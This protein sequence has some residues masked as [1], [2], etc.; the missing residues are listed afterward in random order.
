MG[1]YNAARICLNGHVISRRVKD[2]SSTGDK[3]CQLCGAETICRCLKCGEIIRGK[4]E[5][6]K[7]LDL[8]PDDSPAPAYCYNCGSP[9]PWTEDALESTRM[10]I[11]EENR[12]STDEK[13]NLKKSLPDIISETPRTSL[14][15]LRFKKAMGHV[16]KFTQDAFSKFAVSTACEAAKIMLGL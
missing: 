5:M 1:Y 9:Y 14:A 7:L 10:V 4:Y 11:D 3:F 13:E 12:L 16:G 15:V 6:D 2:T 8:R